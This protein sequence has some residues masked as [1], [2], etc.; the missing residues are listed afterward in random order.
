[1]FSKIC[2]SVILALNFVRF[3][4]AYLSIS[5]IVKLLYLLSYTLDKPKQSSPMNFKKIFA[6]IFKIPKPNRLNKVLLRNADIWII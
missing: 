2:A 3:S 6:N 4:F 5:G 1:V